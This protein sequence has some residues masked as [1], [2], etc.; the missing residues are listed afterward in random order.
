MTTAAFSLTE[1]DEQILVAL[2]HHVRVLSLEDL[3]QTFFG[4]GKAIESFG[5]L[6]IRELAAAGLLSIES[7]LAR[8]T[9]DVAVPVI[10]WT[11]G[12]EREPEFGRVSYRLKQRWTEL[13]KP[14]D[15]VAATRE[16]SRMTGGANAGYRP[17]VSEVTHDVHLGRIYCDHR[18][19]LH[20]TELEW[21]GEGQLRR[22]RAGKLFHG[23]IPDAVIRGVGESEPR[24]VIDFGGSY[25]AAKL[26][27]LHGAFSGYCYKVY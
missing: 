18:R 21:I 8:P 24:M 10:D 7:L 25:S 1:R 3:V 6:R 14:T 27:D 13:P 26:R 17:R 4:K 15:I 22:E 11:P 16:A 23:R 12:R 2:S 20:G 19:H 9:L 5:A